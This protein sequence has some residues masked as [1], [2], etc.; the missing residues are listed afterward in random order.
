MT[1]K[2]DLAA[3]AQQSAEYLRARVLDAKKKGTMT[4][5]LLPSDLENW[6]ALFDVLADHYVAP[7]DG[8]AGPAS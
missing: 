7:E 4:V 3:L 2:T 8:S 6:A 1:E 5:R